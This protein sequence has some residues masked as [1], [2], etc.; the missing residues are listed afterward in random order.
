MNSQLEGML[1]DMYRAGHSDVYVDKVKAI[2]NLFTEQ[3]DH[4]PT[5]PDSAELEI[6][7]SNSR[8]INLSDYLAAKQA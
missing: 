8:E 6:N 2:Y 4:S 7:F 1:K 3:T 5:E